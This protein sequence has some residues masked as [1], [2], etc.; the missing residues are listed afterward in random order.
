MSNEAE[1]RPCPFCGSQSPIATDQYCEDGNWTVYCGMCKST[2]GFYFNK[3]RAIDSWNTR[4][5]P[6]AP[7]PTDVDVIRRAEALNAVAEYGGSIGNP[8]KNIMNAIRA[9]PAISEDGEVSGEQN[10]LLNLLLHVE[11]NWRT[12]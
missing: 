5:A 2:C 3:Q 4:T 7:V 12:D 9:L 8:Y 10:D 6:S 1:L 11:T